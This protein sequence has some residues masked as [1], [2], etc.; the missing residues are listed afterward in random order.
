MYKTFVVITLAAVAIISIWLLINL[1]GGCV[2]AWWL[3][4]GKLNL[5]VRGQI[6]LW[7][8]VMILIGLGLFEGLAHLKKNP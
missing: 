4:W 2:L 3:L 7:A 1:G 6:F 8:L 5:P